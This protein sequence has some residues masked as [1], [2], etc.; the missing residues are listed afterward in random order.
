VLRKPGGINATCTP[1]HDITGSEAANHLPEGQDAEVLLELMRKSES[2]FA[3]QPV[4]QARIA[5]GDAPATQIWLWGHGPRP[6]LPLFKDAYGVSGAVISAVA[7]MNS[8]G[9]YLGL[10]ALDVPGITGYLDTNYAGKGSCAV[11]ALSRH[12]LVFI[13]V[14]APDECGHQ[15]DAAGKVAALERIDKDIVGPLLACAHATA[16]GLRI[17]VCPD[18]PTPLALK[19]HA[20]EPVPFVAWGPGF[21][22]GGFKFN[23]SQAR[24]SK[25]YV[26]RGYELM[27]K[28]L[29]GEIG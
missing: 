7:L 14:E 21:A 17:L 24:L 12:D 6:S 8:M 23:E 13:H 5:A 20:T 27:G 10:E 9:L 29:R 22:P 2:V 3:G 4:N 25:V 15:G 19:T 28:F 16:G 26:S 1:P 11:E 18:H